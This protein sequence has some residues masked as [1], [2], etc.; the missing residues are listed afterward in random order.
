[1]CPFPFLRCARDGW[2]AHNHQRA[3][4]CRHRHQCRHHHH[5]HH[6]H[7]N[8]TTTTTTTTTT[9][10]PPPPR[11]PPPTSP[12]R[13]LFHRSLPQ[14]LKLRKPR[15]FVAG[16][17]RANLFF[18]VRFKDIIEKDYDLASGGATCAMEDDDDD[19]DVPPS[20]GMTT[21]GGG[22]DT[23]QSGTSLRSPSSSS[24]FS[25]SSLSSPRPLPAVTNRPVARRRRPRPRTIL[26]D[27]VDTIRG[28]IGDEPSA[29]AAAAAAALG[30]GSSVRV[31]P[32]APDVA[33]VY[34]F[35]KATADL[36]ADSLQRCGVTALAY[37]R[38]VPA[39][40]LPSLRLPRP[41][42]AT[43]PSF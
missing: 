2:L 27:L 11:P 8:S 20:T 35:K 37:H 3:C 38:R 6:H 30:T 40:L 29:G 25:S 23:S 1:M 5:H 36:L 17:F 24:S 12:S 18:S 32:C 14:V 31:P 19:D 41:A 4:A 7:R 43:L 42:S 34:T 13:P 28:C 33:I 26:A 9:T 15:E 39:L 21:A 10:L 16:R 22:H